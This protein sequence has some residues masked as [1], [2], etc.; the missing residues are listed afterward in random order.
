M[1]LDQKSRVFEVWNKSKSALGGVGLGLFI[2]HQ[3]MEKWEGGSIGVEERHD[4][5]SGACFYIKF[6]LVYACGEIKTPRLHFKRR[7]SKRL[8]DMNS[9][10]SNRRR[11]S[12]WFA[13]VVDDNAINRRLFNAMMRRIG[14]EV[15]VLEYKDGQEAVERIIENEEKCD[16]IFMDINMP[17]MGGF[18][19]TRMIR[20]WERETRRKNIPIFGVTADK[21]VAQE[22][23][24]C[25]MNG[26]LWKPFTVKDL[27]LIMMDELS[28][29]SKKVRRRY[30]EDIYF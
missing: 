9:N 21:T 28:E 22:C 20:K 4:G 27:K 25:D 24:K 26:V 5:E 19:A 1:R 15:E 18:E 10:N 11:K 2:S 17:R 12:K 3:I 30:E 6:P 23:L 13:A 8:Q 16:I 7:K 29:V 14:E